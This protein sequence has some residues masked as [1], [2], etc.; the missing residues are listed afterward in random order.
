MKQRQKGV[1]M[2]FPGWSPPH[3]IVTGINTGQSLEMVFLHICICYNNSS[4]CCFLDFVMRVEASCQGQFTLSKR[5]HIHCCT[6]FPWSN[7]SSLPSLHLTALPLIDAHF[8]KIK[9][10]SEVIF[11]SLSSMDE[12]T[13]FFVPAF[14][15]PTRLTMPLNRRILPLSRLIRGFKQL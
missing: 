1:G 5:T 15:G 12:R 7:D 13:D 4:S 9:V 11:V 3:C 14:S 10:L 2:R 6:H 8:W